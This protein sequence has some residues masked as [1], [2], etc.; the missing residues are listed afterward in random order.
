M[1]DLAYYCQKWSLDSLEQIAATHSS[2]VYKVCMSDGSFAVLKILNEKGQE[3]EAGGAGLLEWY[4]GKGAARLYAYDEKAVLLEYVD[5][6]EVAELVLLDEDEQSTRV[7]CTVVKQL[8]Q[9]REGTWP[10]LIP[11]KTWFQDLYVR[12]E[13]SD[14][15]LVAEA[16]E[17]ADH[18]FETTVYEIPLHGDIHHHNIMKSERGWLAIDPQA[19]LGDPCYDAANLYGNPEG[20]EEECLSEKRIHMIADIASEVLGYDRTRLLQF[21]F[22]HNVISTVWSGGAGKNEEQRR[23]VACL[24]KKHF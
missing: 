19:L 8:H 15:V 10:K 7:I 20:F 6:G 23:A 5:G 3:F 1:S 24:I 4:G 18:L 14:D 22:V 12:E 9:K 13:Q 21:G 11:L 16:V 17:M 2:Y